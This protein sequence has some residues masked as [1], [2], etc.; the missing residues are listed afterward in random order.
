MKEKVKALISKLKVENKSLEK[1]LDYSDISDKFEMY[2]IRKYEHTKEII[3]Q[4]KNC[5]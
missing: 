3:Q 1:D 4:L 2:K 5:L